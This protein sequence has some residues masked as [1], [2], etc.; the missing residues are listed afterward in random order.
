MRKSSLRVGVS[1]AKRNH[2]EAFT[3]RVL[4]FLLH[5]SREVLNGSLDEAISHRGIERFDIQTEYRVFIP[6]DVESFDRDRR[7]DRLGR[8][9][10]A[11]VSARK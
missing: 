8:T 5:G 3:Y 10:T 11:R 9:R 4:L 1:H 6:P 2:F 7:R